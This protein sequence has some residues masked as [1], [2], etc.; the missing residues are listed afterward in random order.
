[1]K[2]YLNY[3][4]LQNKM[5]QRHTVWEFLFYLSLLSILIWLILKLTGVINSPVLV[6]FGV[7]IL[8]VILAFFTLYKD[9]LDRIGWIGRGLTK[10]VTKVEYLEKGT[11][12][13]QRDV[14]NIGNKINS[15]EKD[16]LV[17]RRGK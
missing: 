9:L 16:F 1:M 7:P 5:P 4:Y 10:V 14:E 8:S 3:D 13:L 6:E 2:R 12:L 17:L 11:E 15:M